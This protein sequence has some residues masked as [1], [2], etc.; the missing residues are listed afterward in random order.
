MKEKGQEVKIL[1]FNQMKGVQS[2]KV[3]YKD[4][5]KLLSGQNMNEL[6]GKYL[7]LEVEPNGK[8]VSTKE[9]KMYDL[10]STA[11]AEQ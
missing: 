5:Q 10:R 9:A 4:G 8:I 2:G 7:L 3:E 6:P 11:V 1:Q